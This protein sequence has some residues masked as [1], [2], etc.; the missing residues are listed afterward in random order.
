MNGQTEEELEENI[1][2]KK[3]L[4]W[5]PVAK[6]KGGWQLC[7]ARVVFHSGRLVEIRKLIIILH[8]HI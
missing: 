6:S 3:L 5:L 8:Y 2:S 1:L 7:P 4:K